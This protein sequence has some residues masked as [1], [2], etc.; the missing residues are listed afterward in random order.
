[1]C[2]GRGL[3][4]SLGRR[5]SSQHTPP[6]G[7]DDYTV[8]QENELEALASIFGDD[9]QDLRNKDPWKKTEVITPT[10]EPP[11]VHLCLRPKGLNNGQG[12]Y[13]T[14]DL[15]VKCPP[16]YPDAPPELEL[17]N[18]KGL[19]NESLHN[20]Q[21]ELTKL[22]VARCGEVRTPTLCYP[23]CENASN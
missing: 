19:S 11:E 22:A 21:S 2:E 5:M 15:Q 1:M 16:T 17:K 12:C 7:T 3:P 6:D 18:A 14:V 9:F 4:C 10:I 23:C 20:L 13:V 8:Q